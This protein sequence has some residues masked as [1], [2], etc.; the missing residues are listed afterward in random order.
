MYGSS[1]HSGDLVL[2]WDITANLIS[3][4]CS[5]FT[6]FYADYAAARVNLRSRRR[7][8]FAPDTYNDGILKKI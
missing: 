7:I 6:D 5:Y 8:Y 2:I 4:K 1:D 3:V